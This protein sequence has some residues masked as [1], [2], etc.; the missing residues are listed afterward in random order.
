MKR[1]WAAAVAVVVLFSGCGVGDLPGSGGGDNT[2]PF[3]FTQGFVFVRAGNIFLADKSDFSSPEQLTTDG[4]NRTPAI[5]PDGKLAVYA[6]G[7]AQLLTV[8]T[9]GSGNVRTV[10]T[11]DATQSNVREPVFSP[12]GSFLVFTFDRG[13]TSAI[14]RVN[15][16]GTGFQQLTNSALSFASPSFFPDGNSLLAIAGYS[17]SQL[18]ML[19][20]VDVTSGSTQTLSNDLGPGIDS[21]A[22][23]IV[24]S[25]DGTQAAYDARLHDDPS[26][27]RILVVALAGANPGFTNQVTEYP[28]DPNVVDSFPTWVDASHV[29]FAS[30]AG[31][32]DQVYVLPS[33]SVKQ[34]GGLTVASASQPSWGP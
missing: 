26:H 2:G 5:S 17:N 32:E 21:V 28:S 19:E 6:Q 16:D 25:K 34:S 18:V 24:I 10:F 3:N 8:A 27:P 4:S 31:G 23:R 33:N 12:D 14:G 20:K 7:G 11:A 13:T 22:N 1:V 9:D 29:G 30:T 15:V